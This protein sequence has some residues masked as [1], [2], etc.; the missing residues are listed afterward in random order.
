M[1]SKI[2]ITGFGGQGILFAGKLLAYT[3]LLNNKEVS[4]L[5][6]YGPEMRGGTAYC[7]VIIS[8]GQIGSP[9]VS[10][11]NV[12]M[13]MNAPSFDKFENDLEKD[14]L[15]FIDS[16][17]IERKTSRSDVNAF[18]FP[19]TQLAVDNDMKTFA[20]MIFVGKF[21]KET[22][23]FTKDDILSA[24]KKSVSERKKDLFDTSVKAIEL[25]FNY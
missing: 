16:T 24:L 7:G 4:W 10:N 12:L 6:S 20:N 21:I 3:G 14:G 2:L 22:K 18:Y 13:C 5:P 1:E 23:L 25:G 8:D 19:A 9:I 15:L 11:P 17:L